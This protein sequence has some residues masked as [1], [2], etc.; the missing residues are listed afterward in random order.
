MRTAYCLALAATLLSLPA[1][2]ATIT[3][4]Y[5]DN[6]GFGIGAT[7]FKDPTVN[8]AS[9]GEAAGTDVQ[10]IG[11]CCSAPGFAPTSTLS[12]GAI[13]GITS[14]QI[15]MSLN[16]FGGDTAPVDGPNSIVLDG[17]AVPRKRLRL[18][19][20]RTG[21]VH[22]DDRQHPLVGLVTCFLLGAVR[23]LLAVRRELRTAVG[24]EVVLRQ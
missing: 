24:R 20:E 21:G 17:M 9:G 2:G 22:V 10:R 6:D 18:A 15:T 23:E 11:T 5:G 3:L 16:G 14:I 19:R 8:S 13:A 7:T 4:F 12:F 1:A